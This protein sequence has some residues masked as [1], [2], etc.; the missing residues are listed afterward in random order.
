MSGAKNIKKFVDRAFKD[1][2]AGILLKHSNLTSIQFET[3]IIDLISDHI[4]NIELIYIDKTIF[5]SKKVSRGSFSRTLSQARRNII[6]AIYTILLLCYI[7]VFDEPPFD[8]YRLLSEK[9]KEYVKIIQTSDPLQ[10]KDILIRIER[11]LIKGIRL[12]SQPK[13]LKIL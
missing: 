8:E 7:D 12:L 13:S 6:S 4:S 3:L 5:R 2:I 1:P 10:A 9:L 11:E